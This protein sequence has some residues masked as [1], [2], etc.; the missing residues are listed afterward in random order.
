MLIDSNQLVGRTLGTCTLQRLLGRGGMGAVYLAQ[1]ERPHRIVAVKVLMPDL[2]AHEDL[3][4]E[5]LIRFRREA[6]AIAALD[7]INIMPIYEYGEEERLAYLVMPYITGGTLRE[8]LR[9][10]G[11]LPL[12]ETIP[13][14]AQT[15]SALDYAHARGIIHRDLK[16]GNI[17]LH[18][19]GRLLLTDFGIAKVVETSP[20]TDQHTPQALPTLTTTGTVIGTPEYFSPEQAAGGPIDQR[21]DVYS[22]G[23]VLYEMLAGHVPFSGPTPV[24][25]AL[26]HAMEP[27][28]PLTRANSDIPDV[29]E[30]V[31]MKAL[32]KKPEARYASAGALAQVLRTAF[33]AYALRHKDASEVKEAEKG[34]MEL[35]TLMDSETIITPEPSPQVQSA[36][37][38]TEDM[39]TPPAFHEEPTIEAA[40]TATP[41]PSATP[42]VH[43]APTVEARIERKSPAPASKEQRSEQAMPPVGAPPAR[44]RQGLPLALSIVSGIVILALLLGGSALYF[45]WLPGGSQTGSNSGSTS[46]NSSQK[47]QPPGAA[48]TTHPS[49]SPTAQAH[50]P[51]PQPLVP[52]G[53]L[54]YS[55]ALPACDAQKNL[56]KTDSYAQLNCGSN[57]TTLLDSGAGHIG[58]VFLHN[59]P[60]GGA[61]PNDYIL[62]V[63]VQENASAQGPFGIFF[64]TQP[65][66]NH[67]GSFAFLVQ[68][69]GF[70][71]GNIYDDTTGQS[72][73]LF[74]S[75]GTALKSGGFSTLDIVVQGNTF[76][77]YID[78]TR[79]GGISSDNYPSGIIGLVADQGTSV[80]FK[81]LAI[82]ALPG[83]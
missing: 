16:P 47:Q 51:A 3:Y 54:L 5:F 58:G 82:Y 53:K 15:A 64:R 56:W 13:I 73:T 8:V 27:P 42:E 72:T 77:L 2:L 31:V 12:A 37:S 35:V 11:R 18:A 59:L 33:N 30:K 68:P 9:K 24:A 81:N 17:L 32:A 34:A 7:H 71:Q 76:S 25:V 22:L 60:D 1:Q 52:A 46:Q 26:K 43:N 14:I 69:S 40:A 10:R 28:P 20:T 67:Q 63:Q 6:D 61:I 79:Q 4:K 19:D 38:E 36:P 44:Q 83:S 48:A 45:H 23:V 78:G 39:E 49:A 21:S 70:W 57:A 74:Q 65:G 55:T 41:V 66:A 80:L 75:Q 62:Q 50:A 29:V